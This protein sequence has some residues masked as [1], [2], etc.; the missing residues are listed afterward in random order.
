V[1]LGRS[2]CRNINSDTVL[3]THLFL[4][5]GLALSNLLSDE[6]YSAALIA[7]I[8]ILMHINVLLRYDVRKFIYS[9]VPESVAARRLE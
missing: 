6:C 5:I 4:L 2:H 1:L 3:K 7:V 8:I 9:P